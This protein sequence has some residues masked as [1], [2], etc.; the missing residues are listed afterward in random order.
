MLHPRFRRLP[1][2]KPPGPLPHGFTLGVPQAPGNNWSIFAEA[3]N[4]RGLVES[5]HHALIL[6]EPASAEAATALAESLATQ[7]F[8]GR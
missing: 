4:A 6:C 7:I 5:S 3:A 8:A 2:G 1:D